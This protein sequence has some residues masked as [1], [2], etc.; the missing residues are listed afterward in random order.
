M[1]FKKFLKYFSFLV[2][3]CIGVLYI[4]NFTV[5]KG[6]GYITRDTFLYKDSSKNYQEI[7]LSTGDTVS[8]L[9]YYDNNIVKVRY[10]DQNQ[11][12]FVGFIDEDDFS[13]YVFPAKM[14]TSAQPET[15]DIESQPVLL[16]VANDVTFKD[17]VT[18]FSNVPKG[19]SVIG[20]YLDNS[21]YSDE[22]LRCE[23]F[24]EEQQIP[25]N[26][27]STFDDNKYNTYIQ[28]KED[29]D[30]VT[31]ADNMD[32]S[33]KFLP[34]AFDVTNLDLSLM[35][36]Y[37]LKDCFLYTTALS[38]SNSSNYFWLSDPNLQT[39]S[40][41]NSTR[42]TKVLKSVTK[43][44]TFYETS[45]FGYAYISDSFEQKLDELYQTKLETINNATK[46]ATRN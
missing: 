22:I 41:K 2:I 19:F 31:I 18:E 17:F 33:F 4:L 27:F 39:T 8:I 36:S 43:A 21:E 10:E 13:T 40:M 32:L 23:S 7:G 6:S 15:T 37:D 45:D 20:I 5:D 12:K 42:N 29:V 44:Y 1:R 46:N 9:A 14:S 30:N 11:K 38:L 3:V 34:R 26:N 35:D 25:Y 24:C 28:S 16:Y